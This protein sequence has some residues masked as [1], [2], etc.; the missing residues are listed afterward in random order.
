MKRET[1]IAVFVVAHFLLTI[2]ASGAERVRTVAAP[3]GGSPQHAVC[4][5]DGTIHLLYEKDNEPLYVKSSDGGATFSEPLQ[6]V[7]ATSRKPGI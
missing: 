2:P 7:D 5:P 4:A 1:V 3:N 6:L